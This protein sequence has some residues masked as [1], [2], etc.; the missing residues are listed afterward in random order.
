MADRPN[1]LFLLTDD[2]RFDTIAA[3]NNPEIHTPNFDRLVARGAAFE[4]AY[5]MGGSSAAVCMPSRVM[6]NTG[7][8]LYHIDGEGQGI[9]ADHIL[10][11]EHLQQAGYDCFAT[12]KWHNGSEAYAR[13]FNAGASIFFGGMQDHW[14]VPVCNF[15]PDGTYPQ[16]KRLMAR[17]GSVINFGNQVYDHIEPA[18][19]STDLFVDETCQWLTARDRSCPFFAYVAFMAPHDPREMPAKYLNLYPDVAERTLPPNYMPEHP[20][21]T[22]FNRIRDEMLEAFPRTERR[23]KKHL[24]EY[25]AMISHLDDRIGDLLDTLEK[26]GELSHTIIVMTGDN[27]LACGQHGL[28]GKQ[29]LYEHSI[30]VPLLISGPGVGSA[31]RLD[32]LCYLIDIYPTLCDLIGV[33]TPESVEGQSLLPMIEGDGKGRSSLVFAMT[34]FQ[35][36]IRDGDMKLIETAVKGTR[37]TQ[38]FDLARDPWEMKNLANE[39]EHAGTLERLRRSLREQWAVMDDHREQQGAAFWGRYDAA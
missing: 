23:V 16:P 26:T 38:L 19:H 12:G 25:Y 3:L 11:G 18:R 4:N 34:E 15:N 29:S 14:N 6:L 39:P 24:T 37:M 21:D 35:R 30:H 8:T 20:F 1:V 33:D 5:I 10:L 31:K 2:Q 9:N 22:G 36:A 7:R 28:M 17:F 32:G 27:G 13:S